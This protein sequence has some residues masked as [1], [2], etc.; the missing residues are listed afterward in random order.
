MRSLRAPKRDG[1]RPR[2]VLVRADSTPSHSLLRPLGTEW[3][4]SLP[5]LGNLAAKPDASAGI[6]EKAHDDSRGERF[7][8]DRS[9]KDKMT[10]SKL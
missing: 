9:Q 1:L 8:F 10:R 7:A 6:L 5:F 3:N 4:P 2:N